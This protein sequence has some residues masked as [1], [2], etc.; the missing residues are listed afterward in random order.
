MIRAL[1]VMPFE[2]NTLKAFVDLELTRVGLV[3]RGAT[4][5]RKGDK[6]WIGLPACRWEADDG[7]HQWTPTLEFAEGATAARKAFQEQAIAAVHAFLD[8]QET[9]A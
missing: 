4:L 8:Q 7:S 6:E 3:I 9:V 2:K 5:H 1:K